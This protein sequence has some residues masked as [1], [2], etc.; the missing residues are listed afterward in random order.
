MSSPDKISLVYIL[1][2]HRVEK[3]KALFQTVIESFEEYGYYD[4]VYQ[5]LNVCIDDTSSD[6]TLTEPILPTPLVRVSAHKENTRH[7][8]CRKLK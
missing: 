7:H 8:I 4:T 5:I 2:K 3:F 1:L 6:S